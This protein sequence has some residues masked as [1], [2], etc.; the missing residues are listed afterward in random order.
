[1]T[2]PDPYRGHAQPTWD[3]RTLAT[4]IALLGGVGGT[5]PAG[6]GHT[7]DSRY[8]PS[9]GAYFLDCEN[10]DGIGTI[11]ALTN[12]SWLTINVAGTVW[13]NP[14]GGFDSGTDYYTTPVAGVYLCQALVRVADGFG[15]S[16]NLGL[17]IST[18]NADGPF[19]QWNK[20]V[21]GGG[22]RCAFDYTRIASFAANV[23]LRLY[24]FQDSG[25]TVN[26]TRAA[27]QIWRIG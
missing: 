21:T 19:F 16:F 25:S 2:L 14:G 5:P 27:L 11:T 12:A 22:G 17:G 23:P 3:T 1:M 7:H 10:G 20:Y 18:A 6:S 26:I 4:L 15:S 9:A 24:A 13:S 8:A